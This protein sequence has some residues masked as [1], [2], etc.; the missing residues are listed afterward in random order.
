MKI[1]I[2]Y[3]SETGNTKQVAEAIYEE[4]SR[5]HDVELVELQDVS[6]DALSNS[7]LVFLG[8]PCH[9]ADLAKSLKRFLAILP[10]NPDFILAG[11]FTH[12]VY[13]PE[14]TSRRKELYEKWAGKCVSSFERVCQE[15]SIK[16]LGYFHCCGSPSPPIETFIHQVIITS[17]EEW[18]EYLSE[19][20]K[21]PNFEDLQNAK[22]FARTIIRRSDHHRKQTNPF[23]P[24]SLNL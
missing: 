15:K 13:M 17:A 19:I 2:A 8:T 4:A 1:L 14:E 7:Q 24:R 11:F 21:H 3:Y 9:D 22:D 18:K 20:R 16:L 5:D 10:E 6:I 12:A 23:P